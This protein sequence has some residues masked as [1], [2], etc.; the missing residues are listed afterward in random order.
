MASC[1]GLYIEPNLIKYAKVSKDRDILRIESFGIK[2]Y[3]R[4]GDAIRQII[5]DTVSFK[6][7][8]SVNLSEEAYDYLYMFSLLNKNDLKKAINTEF[9]A[10]CAEK[11]I[12]RNAFE[13][14]YAL[15][16]SL[17]DKEKV[18]VIHVSSNKNSINTLEQSLGE[19]K[20][21]TISP[22]GITIANIANLKE[23]ENVLI[24]NMQEKTTIT[25]IVDQKIYNVETIEEGAK[26]VLD[27]INVKENSYSKAYEICKNSTIYTMEGKDLQD[28]ENEYLDDIMPTLYKIATKVQETL[29]TQTIKI[30]KIYITGTLSVVNNID[31][32][33]QEFFQ[34]EKCEVMK[35][36]FL[37]DNIKINMKDYIEVNSAIALALQGLGY[38]LKD[39]NFKKRD[40]K[41]DLGDMFS[42]SESGDGKKSKKD[43]LGKSINLS[44]IFKFNLGEKLDGIERWMLRLGGGILAL[45]V[46]YAAFTMFLNHQIQEKNAEVAA[47]K[48]DTQTQIAAVESDI[49]KINQKTNQYQQLSDNLKN[50]SAQ[51]AD[52]SKNKKTIPNLLSQIMF[53][54]PQGV[55]V[56]SIDNTTSRHVV[57]NAQSEKYEQL[58]I[59]KAI[60][61]TQGILAPDTIVS[62][63]GTKQGNVV[64]IVIEGDLP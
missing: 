29:A 26:T 11:N 31:L 20:A 47:V 1:L 40:W 14:R 22:I 52:K 53:A 43:I 9:E 4:L 30:N 56:T 25:T 57:I 61:K 42:K 27:S 33:F 48:S 36:Y 37:K 38:G 51:V 19:Y 24:I 3:D 10:M 8:I 34:T 50:I 64:Q 59:F 54:I 23:K 16:N 32:Y 39:M 58:G 45:T 6:V 12:N 7:P 60:L 46:I 21:T 55:Q 62:S 35:P 41:D 13:T 17:E 28:E 44:G 2:F 49:S 63:S 18:K 5:A 15:A